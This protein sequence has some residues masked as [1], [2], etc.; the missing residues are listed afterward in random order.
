MS[1]PI[2]IVAFDG[3]ELVAGIK[4]EAAESEGWVHATGHV[5]QAELKLSGQGADRRRTVAARATL[6]SF[7]GPIGG[8]YGATLVRESHAGLELHAGILMSARCLGVTAAIFP[9]ELSESLRAGRSAV[10]PGSGEDDFEQLL[11]EVGDLIRH[12]AFGLCEVV[13]TTGDRLKIRDMA[14]PG[15]VREISV[16][17]LKVEGPTEELGKRLFT[18]VRKA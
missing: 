2:R 17:R 12:F 7:G 5:E 1:T 8:P 6:A 3:E 10:K 13:M 9:A 4:R 15:R 11:P 18:I 14:E 16:E